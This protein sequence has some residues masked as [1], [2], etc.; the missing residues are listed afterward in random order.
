MVRRLRQTSRKSNP[1]DAPLPQDIRQNINSFNC[2]TKNW[3]KGLIREADDDSQFN[4]NHKPFT[5][6]TRHFKDQELY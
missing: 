5:P 3:P 2:C 6:I 1:S 4:T